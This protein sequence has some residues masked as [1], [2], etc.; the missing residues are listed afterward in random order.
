MARIRTLCR[1]GMLLVLGAT[2]ALVGC[3]KQLPPNRFDVLTGTVQALHADLGQLTVRASALRPEFENNPYVHCVLGND[4]EVYINDKFSAIGAIAV[5]DTAELIGYRDPN[6]EER[7][8]VCL[9][10]IT[11]SEPLP[12]APDLSAAA[13]QSAA[14]RHREHGG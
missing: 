13:T 2:W 3:D 1:P 12:P 4:A 8:L 11:R 5:G 7:F 10:H 14:A 6:R 9:V